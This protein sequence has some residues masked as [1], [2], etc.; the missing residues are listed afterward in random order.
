MIIRATPHI[1]PRETLPRLKS[2]NS[3]AACRN[4]RNQESFPTPA[5]TDQERSTKA[6]RS[7]RGRG[8]ERGK[9]GGDHEGE[10]GDRASEGG[11]KREEMRCTTWAMVELVRNI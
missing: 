5:R 7:A 4:R 3:L 6:R 11:Y 1:E 2:N 8:G 10:G 9:P